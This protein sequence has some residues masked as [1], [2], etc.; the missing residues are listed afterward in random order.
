MSAAGD[1]DGSTDSFDLDQY[2][3][4]D[5]LA[6]NQ[7]ITS[8]QARWAED[9]TSPPP[10]VGGQPVD[11]SA[12]SGG[13]DPEDAVADQGPSPHDSVGVSNTTF[14]PSEA[15][16]VEKYRVLQA[17]EKGLYDNVE[18]RAQ[19]QAEGHRANDIEHFCDI[20]GL[21]SHM[22]PRVHEVVE[23]VDLKNDFRHQ[24][25]AE[26][27]ILAAITIACNEHDTDPR[28][29]SHFSDDRYVDGYTEAREVCG[30]KPEVVR[31]IRTKLS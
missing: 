5:Y 30:T 20:V 11:H 19:Q 8:T 15:D 29:E 7:E 17:R 12:S 24:T 23:N 25:T 1:S 21:E 26:D 31:R 14:N 2:H 10:H 3:D 18:S 6:E 13:T 16:D 4:E 22:V 27:V 28:P 9:T